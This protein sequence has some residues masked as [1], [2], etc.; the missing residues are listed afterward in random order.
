MNQKKLARHVCF[1][2]KEAR[3]TRDY[4]IGLHARV[5]ANIAQSHLS[6]VIEIA[7]LMKA[8]MRNIAVAGRA[9]FF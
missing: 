1:S 4:G 5:T 8:P 7:Q 9:F 3:A 2:V 6:N